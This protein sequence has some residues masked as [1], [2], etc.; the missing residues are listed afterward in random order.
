MKRDWRA[1]HGHVPRTSR[2]AA[3]S[4]LH[5]VSRPDCPVA[6]RCPAATRTPVPGQQAR[7]RCMRSRREPGSRAYAT[8]LGRGLGRA[9]LQPPR[10]SLPTRPTSAGASARLG[11]RPAGDSAGWGLGLGWGLARP[12]AAGASRE[13]HRT[14]GLR[15]PAPPRRATR[16]RAHRWSGCSC[17]QA[18]R[19]SRKDTAQHALAGNQRAPRAQRSETRARRRRRPSARDRRSRAPPDN[20][21]RRLA[22]SPGKARQHRR[23]TGRG[24]GHR[25]HRAQAIRELWGTPE[26][27]APTDTDG[28]GPGSRSSTSPLARWLPATPANPR[29]AR[30]GGIGRAR[31]GVHRMRRRL[32]VADPQRAVT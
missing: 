3:T 6:G 20:F 17:R 30:R 5:D 15:P 32:L 28:T 26:P 13:G 4:H 10:I 24:D 9:G 2:A 18:E 22:A 29:F 23:G 27:G 19:V 7:Q 14:P 16:R 25:F 12:R 31:R 8:N 21:L 11:P 1:P